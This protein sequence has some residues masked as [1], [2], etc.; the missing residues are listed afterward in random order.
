M[1]ILFI[2]LLPFILFGCA[3]TDDKTLSSAGGQ[4]CQTLTIGN[5]SSLVINGHIVDCTTVISSDQGVSTQDNRQELAN[6]AI[7]I[8]GGIAAN[9]IS[10]EKPICTGEGV[11]VKTCL[12]A[13]GT[14]P[15]PEPEPEA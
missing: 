2:L 8:E 9:N 13:G 10:T 3:L 4:P 12:A 6:P 15:P 1:K 5:N 14:L 7:P 11:S